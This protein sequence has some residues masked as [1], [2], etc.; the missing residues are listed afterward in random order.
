[1]NCSPPGSSVHG[2]F[3]AR[4]LEW[5]AISFSRGS[6]QPRDRTRVSCTAGRFSADWATREALHWILR[7]RLTLHSS[8]AWDTGRWH[9]LPRVTHSVSSGVWGSGPRKSGLRV[10][11]NH[12]LATHDSWHQKWPWA[13]KFTATKT[14][15]TVTEGLKK[16]DGTDLGS[17]TGPVGQ[18]LSYWSWKPV[19]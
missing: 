13:T 15:V 3:Q 19:D 8:V 10:L 9:L 7:I 1:M 14:A 16:R 11:S 4:I 2:I 17:G 12:H 5:V 6:S 18:I